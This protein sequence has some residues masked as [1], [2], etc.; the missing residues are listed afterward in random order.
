MSA[1]EY[2]QRDAERDAF[3]RT[4]Y[5]I[6]RRFNV[7]WSTATPEVRAFIEEATRVTYEQEKAKRNGV[8]L[9]TV[10]PFFWRYSVLKEKAHRCRERS[11]ILAAAQAA[12][13][14]PRA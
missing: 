14:N 13:K 6:C 3:Y 11:A 10:K 2:F 1:K 7:T 5:Q 8:S 9:S 4:F 12:I